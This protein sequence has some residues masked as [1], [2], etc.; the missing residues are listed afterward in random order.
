[1]QLAQ[2]KIKVENKE[3]FYLGLVTAGNWKLWRSLS[4]SNVIGGKQTLPP[5]ELVKAY[6]TAICVPQLGFYVGEA[7]QKGRYRKFLKGQIGSRGIVE[8]SN[9]SAVSRP[10]T[11]LEVCLN[12]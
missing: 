10:L 11:A 6:P 4:G 5:E 9:R 7:I 1:M 2:Q 3:L 12:R 8:G